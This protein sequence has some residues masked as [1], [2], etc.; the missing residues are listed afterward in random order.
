MIENCPSNIFIL[1]HLGNPDVRANEDKPWRAGIDALSALPNVNC[2]ISGIITRAGK[3]WKKKQIAPYIQYVIERFGMDRLVYG[4]DWPVVLRAGSYQSW[5]RA[6]EKI[7]RQ[8]A[9]ADLIKIYHQNA[10]RI[11]RLK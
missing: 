3:G 1:D 5:S 2:K 4:G 9:E 7:T 10:D 8:Y 6:F 11:Y